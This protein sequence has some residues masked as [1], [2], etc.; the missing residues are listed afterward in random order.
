M[1]LSGTEILKMVE[2]GLL[3]IEPKPVADQI[4][5]TAVDLRM[6]KSLWLWDREAIQKSGKKA[7]DGS[8]RVD[9]DRMNYQELTE[10][11]L[12]EV[13][14]NGAGKYVIEPEQVYLASTHEKV[15]LP[16]GSLLAARIEGKSSLARLGLAVHITAPTIHCGT[17]LGIITL[18]MYNQGPFSL[19]ITPG[20]SRICQLILEQVSSEPDPRTGRTFMDQKTPKG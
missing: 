11:Y 8:L 18:E 9:V 15:A 7:G 16:T 2:K 19:E 4:D 14:S 12:V 17:G 13:N 5:A 10:R 20:V 6:G 3:V 1:I